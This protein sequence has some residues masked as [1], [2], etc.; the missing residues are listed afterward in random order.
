MSL[1]ILL[2]IGLPIAVI[3][4]LFL[5]FFEL[6]LRLGKQLIDKGNALEVEISERQKAQLE[7]ETS[8]HERE[9]LLREIHH[10][11]KNNMQIVSSLLRI[12]S[13]RSDDQATQCILDDCRNRVSAMALIHETLY[14]P[15]NL[16]SVSLREYIEELIAN[17]FDS[18]GVEPDRITLVNDV[19]SIFLNIETATPCGLII[20]ELVT[21]CL[22][23]AFP[24]KRQGEITLSLKRNESDK[25]YLLRVADNGIGLPSDLDI[26]QA[27]SLGLQLVVNLTEN[28]LQGKVEV[29]RGDGVEFRVAFHEISYAKRL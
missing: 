7:A 10:R 12:Q 11:V 18:Y 23:Y 25:G 24:D 22:K 3:A 13:R 14:K 1:F 20:N 9:L 27:R 16:N 4:G 15:S 21:N 2:L 26:R 8:L 28:Q 17:L 29:L 19:E 5:L 6:N